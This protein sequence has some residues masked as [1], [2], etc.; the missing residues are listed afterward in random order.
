[1]KGATLA[2]R[3]KL[4]VQER[5]QISISLH[6]KNTIIVKTSCL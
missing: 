4:C 5:T 1:M 3:S 2:E 6:H